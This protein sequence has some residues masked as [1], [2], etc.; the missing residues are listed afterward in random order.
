MNLL[1]SPQAQ[2]AYK[3]IQNA[4]NNKEIII[5]AAKCEVNYEGRSFSRLGE[6]DRIILI[7]PDGATII[8]RPEGYEPVNWQ[9]SG[10]IVYCQVEEDKLVIRV[11]RIKPYEVLVIRFMD[12]YMLF[13]GKLEDKAIFEMWGTEEDIKKAIVLDPTILGENFK[14]VT[15]ER[16]LGEGVAD[17]LLVDQKGRY[18]VVEIKKGTAGINAVE[19]LRKY[20]EY[21]RKSAGENVR[22]ILVA[23]RI[24]RKAEQI[25]AREGLEFKR[26]DYRKVWRVLSSQK[27]ILKFLS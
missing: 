4:V 2:E 9:P 5:L 15:D 13:A 24:S 27:G 20:V 22:G 25:I 18:V 26:I 23:P 8:H 19:Q 16:K 14:V 7:K 3:V 6:G 21:F 10:S 12:I 17:I 11:A 1:K